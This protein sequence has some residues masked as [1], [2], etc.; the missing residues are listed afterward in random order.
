LILVLLESPGRRTGRPRLGHLRRQAEVSQDSHHGRLFNQR[1]KAQ[2]P[3]APRA[4]QNVEPKRP[5]H[6]LG[7][8]I[9]LRSRRTATA[10][11]AVGVIHVVSRRGMH[12]QFLRAAARSANNS[13]FSTFASTSAVHGS[14]PSGIRIM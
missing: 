5:P 4:R 3:A 12:T 2:P 10:R 14:A 13:N 6:E 1:H 9:A 11:L 7:P 8:L